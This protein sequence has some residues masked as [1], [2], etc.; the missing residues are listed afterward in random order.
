MTDPRVIRL[1]SMDIEKYV[2]EIL[3]D[4]KKVDDEILSV[5]YTYLYILN[6]RLTLQQEPPNQS[7][8]V[9]DMD[10][11]SSVLRGRGVQVVQPCEGIGEIV[12]IS[13][14]PFLGR[15]VET[16]KRQVEEMTTMSSAPPSNAP[17]SNASQLM[18]DADVINLIMQ[19]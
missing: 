19:E 17:Q 16:S 11:L 14:S 3:A 5:R 7:P 13:Y 18:S 10:L 1:V 4:A 9:L 2:T 6:K 15:N 12:L 8:R